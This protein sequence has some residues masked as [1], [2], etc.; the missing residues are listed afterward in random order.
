M[1]APMQN[2]D[3]ARAGSLL[4]SADLRMP[5][6][7]NFVS[8]THAVTWVAFGVSISREEWLRDVETVD[9]VEMEVVRHSLMRGCERLL[10]AANVGSVQLVGKFFESSR[11][12]IYERDRGRIP[13]DD[14]LEFRR[15]DVFTDGLHRSTGLAWRP[16]T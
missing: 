13:T 7:S 6:S 14:L 8:L 4:K 3:A 2:T 12:G 5:P 1:K 9:E 11:G 16:L 10:S 15:F